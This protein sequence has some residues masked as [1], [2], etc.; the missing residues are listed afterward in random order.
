MQLFK[1]NDRKNNNQIATYDLAEKAVIAANPTIRDVD[2][3]R[4]IGKAINA[5]SIQQTSN[6]QQAKKD[7]LDGYE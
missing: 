2:Q 5:K 4:E 7:P 1:Y 3:W 6:N